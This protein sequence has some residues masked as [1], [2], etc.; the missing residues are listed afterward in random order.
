MEN[1]EKELCDIFNNSQL[2]LEAKRYVVV[3]FAR[4]VEDA[5]RKALTLIAEQPKEEGSTE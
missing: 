1:F 5:Y 4:D 2:P 3:K